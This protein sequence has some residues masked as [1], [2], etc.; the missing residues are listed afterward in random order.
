[1]HG[2]R[3][4][5]NAILQRDKK[6]YAIIPH[7]PGGLTNV[8]QLKKIIKVA[9]KYNIEVI[10]VTSAQRIALIGFTED[11]L[12]SAW[13]DLE[14]PRAKATGKVVRSVK[15]CPG[16]N[17]CKYGLQDSVKLGLKI[18]EKYHGIELPNKVKIGVSGCKLGCA[19]SRIKDIGL[20]GTKNGWMLVVGGSAGA[21]VREAQVLADGLSEEQVFRLIDTIFDYYREQ[22]SNARLGALIEN[23]GFEKFKEDILKR[24]DLA[25]SK[26][27]MENK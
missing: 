22:P 10:K 6:T 14:M 19:E 18:D 4:M 9:E 13:A 25:C 26:E 8:E 23:I 3:K 11:Q 24:A 20:L 2:I 12:E 5:H 7:M 16:N 15:I 1:M 21:K 27:K 17:L